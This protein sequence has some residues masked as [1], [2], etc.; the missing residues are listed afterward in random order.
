M[1]GSDDNTLKVWDA[2]P[3]QETLT[4]KGHSESVTSVSY[5]PEGKRIISSSRDNTVKIWDARL[6]AR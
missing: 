5:S 6:P 3:G 4:L 1:S 2:Q